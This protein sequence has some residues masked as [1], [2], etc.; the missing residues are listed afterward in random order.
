MKGVK[1]VVKKVTK[2]NRDLLTLTYGAIVSQIV[3]DTDNIKEAN[4]QLEKLGFDIGSRL[5]DEFV[6]KS[7][8]KLCQDYKEMANTIAKEGFEMFLG[9]KGELQELKADSHKDIS[10]NIELNENPLT[11]FV[12]I[13][14]HLAG[15]SYNNIIC[16]A[17][18][19]A[20]NSLLLIGKVYMKQDQ[21][22]GDEK[23]IIRVECKREK[24]KD[25]D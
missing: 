20:I 3:K 5:I 16:G 24:L 23:T 4:D 15:L 7:E 10:F 19:G 6:A 11:D 14:E 13:P 25:E 17:I 22:L 8:G 2:I 9:V 18:R 1:P 21:L 12:E